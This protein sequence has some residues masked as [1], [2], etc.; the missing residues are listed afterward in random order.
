MQE[1][2]GSVNHVLQYTMNQPHPFS[3]KTTKTFPVFLYDTLCLEQSTQEARD[4]SSSSLFSF[5]L[6]VLQFLEDVTAHRRRQFLRIQIR[7]ILGS[8]IQI[9]HQSG[10]LDS[11]PRQSE[12]V[13]IFGVSFWSTEGYKSGK[14]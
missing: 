3:T 12:N 4:R 7:I 13:E 1:G 10:K 2:I 5:S 9:R 8:W 11:D 14:K 6:A